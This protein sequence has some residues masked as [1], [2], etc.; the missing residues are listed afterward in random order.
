MM[1]RLTVNPVFIIAIALM[2]MTNNCTH[3]AHEANN[4]QQ[5]AAGED[6]SA[7]TISKGNNQFA[8][9]ILGQLPHEDENLVI[10]PFS[11][12]T[13]I[14][15]TYAGAR[16][17]TQE[18]MAEI[19]H[20]DRDQDRFHRGYSNY[21]QSLS[22]LIEED[23]RLNIANSLWAQE[24]YHFLDSFFE[25]VQ[26]NY[27]SETFQVD[28][29]TNR[30][31]IRENINRWVYD[32]TREK[33]EDL[34]APGVLTRDTRLVL[35]NAIHFWGAWMKEFDPE[36]TKEDRFFMENDDTVMADFM[37]REDTLPYYEDE[38]LQALE[39]PYS[40]GDFSMMMVLPREGITTRDIEATLD[41]QSFVSLT[42]SM[43]E[44]ALKAFIPKFEGE[45][46]VDL[47]DIF[48]NMGMELPFSRDA[49]FSG[50]T[51]DLELV[52]DKVIHQA[53][54]EVEEEGTEAA[55][56]TAVVVIRK[57]A[58]DPDEPPVFRANRPFLFYIKDNI[59]QSILFAG[60][61]MNPEK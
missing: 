39:I 23:I 40:G 47:E 36:L 32:E 14:A 13:A 42:D 50:M 8:F 17:G 28:F 26:Q 34:I 18:Q 58:I 21:L 16:E 20:F 51:G 24:D 37:S 35:V 48:M 49:D 25:I 52:I 27:D 22:E 54:I 4:G 61:V 57:T 43:E 45:T 29:K 12:S 10:S 44:T 60:R 46:K 11:I 56:A 59:N 15:M 41:A 5:E 19:M 38:R 7:A 30:E 6:I 31:E 9:D 3:R 53:M 2:I 55:A 33:I 1:T